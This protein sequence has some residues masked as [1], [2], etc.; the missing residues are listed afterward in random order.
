MGLNGFS[1]GRAGSRILNCSP[2]WR[3]SR[4]AAIFDSSFFAEQICVQLLRGLVV[5]RQLGELGF[6]RRNSLDA[7]L[8]ARR[9]LAEPLLFGAFVGD[10][11]I[12]ALELQLQRALP[13][14]LQQLRQASW[15][16]PIPATTGRRALRPRPA[17]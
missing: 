11:P 17:A 3:R 13:I 1:A 16:Q 6:A 14:S 10:L 8:I 9:Q 12:E 15:A 2:I 4:F 5:A 7:R